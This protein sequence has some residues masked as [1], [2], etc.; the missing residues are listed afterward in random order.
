MKIKKR[1]LFLIVVSIACII[2]LQAS[3][4]YAIDNSEPPAQPILPM[5]RAMGD[6]FT[7]V[8]NDENTIFYNPAG[9]A[10]ITEGIIS[11][12]S[13]GIKVNIDDSALKLYSALISGKD[14]TASGNLDNYLSDTT[15]APAITG[16]IYFGRVGNNFGFAFFDSIRITMDT[17]PGGLLP[18]ADFDAYTDLGFVGGYGCQLPW[19][20]NLYGGIN[21][22]VL[23]RAKSSIEGTVLDVI[24]TVGDTSEIP[25]AKAVGFGADLGLLYLPYPWMSV[26]LNAKDFFGTRFSSWEALN[27]STPFPRSLIKPRLAFGVAF[28]PLKEGGESKNFKNFIIAVDYSD[29]FDYS[30]VLSNVKLGVSFNTLRIVN[31]RAGF[32]GGYPTFGIGF[33][34]NIFHLS[35]VYFVDELGA[36]TGAQPV[37]NGMIDFTFKW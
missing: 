15:V 2:I 4:L 3:P 32:D 26:G 17:R 19:V 23:L 11:V 1:H 10:L 7:A 21:L 6:A 5:V 35:I 33:D 27:Q 16:P 20:K 34:L 28:Y 25:F 22:K 18:T 29:L 8:A 37:Q 24:D 12:F 36:Y 30:V 14:V 13:L 9:Y 31:L